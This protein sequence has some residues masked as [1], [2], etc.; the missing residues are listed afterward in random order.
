MLLRPAKTYV[1]ISDKVNDFKTLIRPVLLYS[2][3]TWVLAEREENQLLEE[4]MT[5]KY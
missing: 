1:V 2:S 4:Y 3:E 5:Q